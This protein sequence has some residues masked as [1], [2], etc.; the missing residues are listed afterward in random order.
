[1]NPPIDKEDRPCTPGLR[2]PRATV[3]P[4]YFN[5]NPWK[6]FFSGDFMQELLAGV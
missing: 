4:T 3:H 1:M 2:A 5:P 6:N